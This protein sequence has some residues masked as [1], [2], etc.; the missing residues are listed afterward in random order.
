MFELANHSFPSFRDRTVL[1]G[2]GSA[3]LRS[4][5]AYHYHDG[6]RRVTDCR[7]ISGHGHEDDAAILSDT[8]RGKNSSPTGSWCG[9]EHGSE[10]LLVDVARTRAVSKTGPI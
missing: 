9:V 5:T 2:A 8:F 1:R 10:N 7:D 6:Q 4:D 3:N